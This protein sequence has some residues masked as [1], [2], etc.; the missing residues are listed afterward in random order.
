MFIFIQMYETYWKLELPEEPNRLL[1]I[2]AITPHHS[3]H[4]AAT[5]NI[6]YILG[7]SRQRPYQQQIKRAMAHIN[8]YE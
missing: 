1:A 5:H 2:I 8:A 4:I 3:R 6:D 7:L